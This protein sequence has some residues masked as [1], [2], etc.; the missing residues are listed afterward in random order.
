MLPTNR[1]VEYQVTRASAIG[2]R[3]FILRRR[4]QVAED[5]MILLYKGVVKRAYRVIN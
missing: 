2:K 3:V 1:F 4:R 5:A